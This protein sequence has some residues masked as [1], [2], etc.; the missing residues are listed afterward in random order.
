M[1]RGRF[2]VAATLLGCAAA[3]MVGEV[4]PTPPPTVPVAVAARALAPGAALTDA[5]VR[6]EYLPVGLAPSGSHRHTGAVVGRSLV[7][8]A[9]VGLPIV[10]GLLAGQASPL[11]P[12]TVLAPVRLTDPAIAALLRPGDRVDLLAAVAAADGVPTAR[13][14]AERAL[15]LPGPAPARDPTP[16]L[17]G[18]TQAT[19]G[20]LT[21]VAVTPA[22]A[23]AMAGAVGWASLSAVVVR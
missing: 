1:W 21:L 9:P 5:D 18:T 19:S 16:G 17:L 12:G 3:L 20:A 13:R 23:V 2:A 8:G 14:L 11:P 10:D 15:V 22:E 4:R 7:V 6:L